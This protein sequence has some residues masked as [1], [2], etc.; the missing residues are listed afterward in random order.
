MG[1]F[2]SFGGVQAISKDLLSIFARRT[3]EGG[4]GTSEGERE[5]ERNRERAQ[6]GR[7]LLCPG[8]ERPLDPD[9]KRHGQDI[10]LA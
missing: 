2:P 10:A 4:D 1:E 8:R 9:R 3:E 6:A 5:R 7:T